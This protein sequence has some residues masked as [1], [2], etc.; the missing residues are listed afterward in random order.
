MIEERKDRLFVRTPFNREFTDAMKKLHGKWNPEEKSWVID[1]GRKDEV[2]ELIEKHFGSMTS[3]GPTLKSTVDRIIEDSSALYEGDTIRRLIAFAYFYGLETGTKNTS[4]Q[5]KAR[6]RSLRKQVQN[7]RY[8]HYFNSIIEE[9][10]GDR[11]YL[12]LQNYTGRITK[13]L[14]DVETGCI[15]KQG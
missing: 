14:G 13:E 1:K 5:Y 15:P 7:S 10:I 12:V 3:S 6:I 11:D 8:H 2:I 9:T 4:D